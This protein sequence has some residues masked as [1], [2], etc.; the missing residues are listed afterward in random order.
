[1]KAK[2]VRELTLEEI[3]QKERDLREEIFNLKFRFSSGQ[4]EDPSRIK[5]AKRDLARVLSILKEKEKDVK[6]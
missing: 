5:I 4:L 1:M 3:R 2:E 6:S